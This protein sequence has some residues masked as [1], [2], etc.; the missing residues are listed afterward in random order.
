MA[1]ILIAGDFCPHDR[2][3]SLLETERYSEVFD[4]V[5]DVINN[6]DYSIVNFETT[7]ADKKNDPAIKKAGPALCT[8]NKAIEALKYAGFNCCT[9][10][11]NHFYDYGQK[12]VEN[13]IKALST[14]GLDYVGAG[15]NLEEASTV[16]FKKI[17]GKRIAIINCCEHEFSIAT[18]T[19]AGC[20]PLNVIQQYSAIKNAKTNADYVIV[21]VH[22][23]LEHLQYPSVRMKE[24]YRF[25]ID[26]GA[27]AV[28]NH[29]QHCYLGMEEY[30]GRPIFYGLGNFCFDWDG[31][32]KE[33][34]NEGY[35]VKL[36]LDTDI[37]YEV[38]PY[39]QCDEKPTVELLDEVKKSSFYEVFTKLSV[40]YCDN[41]KLELVNREFAEK[42]KNRYN[43]IFEPYSGRISW[44][45]YF[46]S[47]LP[48]FAKKN[49]E[50]KINFIECESHR[51][52]LLKHLKSFL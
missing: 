44:A 49:I 45:L 4:G 40:D 39:I 33:I 21:I 12:G 24:A 36:V 30:K 28:I 25:F 3:V 7:I 51:D 43:M 34:W 22:G 14:Q 1:V 9:L 52:A 5:R 46:R 10:A 19:T 48:S 31:K 20:N 35:M 32:R 15:N 26:A 16:L 2:L 17:G 50:T 37:Q 13:S 11:N 8:T 41:E 18:K 47:L 38:I 23:G 6:S 29:H 42:M 27:D